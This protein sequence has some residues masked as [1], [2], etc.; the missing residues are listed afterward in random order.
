MR[1]L[2]L[3]ISS[4]LLTALICAAADIGFLVPPS[5]GINNNFRDN[6]Q[7]QTGEIINITWAIDSLAVDLLLVIQLPNEADTPA[8]KYDD[9]TL[10]RLFPEK[11]YRWVVDLEGFDTAKRV[12]DDKGQVVLFFLISEPG[13][14]QNYTIRSH[15]FNVTNP[16]STTASPTTMQSTPA[17]IPISTAT[18]TTPPRED[19]VTAK[20]PS[21]AVIGGAVGGS[22]GGLLVLAGLAYFVWRHFRNRKTIPGAGG[23][24]MHNRTSQ[25][26]MQKHEGWRRSELDSS[27]PPAIYE[28]P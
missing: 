1:S 13:Q 22:I 18:T 8:E 20:S 19:S 14:G 23:S 9:I 25:M 4:F 16:A 7:Y 2:A 28:V 12:L 3:T 5:A 15:Y 27:P 6:P 24:I 10:Q 21:A 17:T 11:Y 26:T